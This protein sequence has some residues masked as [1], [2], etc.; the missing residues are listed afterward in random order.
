MADIDLSTLTPRDQD[1]ADSL[2]VMKEG[3]PDTMGLVPRSRF[4]SAQMITAAPAT[5]QADWAPSGFG[6][7]TGEILLQPTTNCWLTGLAAGASNQMVTLINDSL[8]VICIEGEATTS[9]A[10]NRFRKIGRT[11]WLLPGESM[12]FRYSSTLAR[13]VLCCDSAMI[14]T[15][16]SGTGVSGFGLG[17]VTTTATI[18]NASPTGGPTNEFLEGMHIQG[19]NS[20]AS[21]TSSVRGSNVAF[22]RG[23]VGNRQGV[24]HAAMVRFTAL[25]ATGAVR[26]GLL[27][28]AA[29]STTLNSALTN[30]MA[31]GADGGQTTL[32]IFHNDGSGAA[33]AID[34]GANFPVPNATAAYEHCF[35]APPNSAFIRYMV[36]RL[37]TRFVAQGTLTTDL[38]DNTFSLCPRVEAM[39]G[40]T[41][42]ANTWQTAFM[43]THKLQ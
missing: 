23:S 37:D 15:P 9:T 4:R 5:D 3:S 38:S 6:A 32:R 12:T 39:V 27:G 42:A 19:T 29:V 33:T 40:A 36:R 18:S 41:G 24:F 35:Y 25:G 2:V 7:A 10:A 26:S 20:T 43:L 31:L 13:W 30:F 14:I 17:G 1:P 28:T 16:S 11:L 8:F 21:G 22:S 34:L